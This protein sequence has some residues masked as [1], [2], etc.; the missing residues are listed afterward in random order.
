M[1][2]RGMLLGAAALLPFAAG[3]AQAQMMQPLTGL[4]IAGGAGFNWV[5]GTQIDP[6]GGYANA[7]GTSAHRVVYS[8]VFSDCFI[9]QGLLPPVWPVLAK[10]MAP[11]P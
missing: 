11:R 8:G 10:A 3:A 7:R 9:V 6:S 5:Q 2:F 4:Y 1:S